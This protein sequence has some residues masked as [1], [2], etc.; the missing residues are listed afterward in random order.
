M[1]NTPATSA[2]GPAL[3]EALR[4][5]PLF[6]DY[7]DTALA[8]VAATARLRRYGHNQ[9]IFHRGD[10]G[11]TMY[12]VASGKVKITVSSD[13]GETALLA[14]L[15]PGEFFGELSLLDG[16]PRSATATAVGAV[17]VWSLYRDD[18]LGPI[19]AVPAAAGLL[20][21]LARRLR[22]CDELLEELCTL[23]LQARLARALLRLADEHGEQRPDGVHVA[24]PL[25]QS[26]LAM[27]VGASRPRVNV[28]LGNYQD[29]GLVRFSGRTL[30]LPD[31]EALR[32]A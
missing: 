26:D 8:R 9:V 3:V 21:A 10:P 28:A 1:K 6:H 2:T 13:T 18:V 5:V 27:M 4:R 17:A 22:R 20:A 23:D 32:S 14:V 11:Q 19:L 24:V 15:C 7:D 31:V 29:A 25:T 16:G 12:I 30:V